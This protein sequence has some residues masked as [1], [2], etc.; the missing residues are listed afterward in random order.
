M[1]QSCSPQYGHQLHTHQHRS[2]ITH[3]QGK[4]IQKIKPNLSKKKKERERERERRRRK[5]EKRKGKKG[6]RNLIC[7]PNSPLNLVGHYVP[8]V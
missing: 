5:K 6:G 7:A 4:S 1:D 3:S 8:S 2:S